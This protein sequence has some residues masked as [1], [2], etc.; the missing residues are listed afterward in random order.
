MVVLNETLIV[1]VSYNHL[2]SRNGLRS[3][4]QSMTIGPGESGNPNGVVE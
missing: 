2:Q 1:L 4:E 3:G